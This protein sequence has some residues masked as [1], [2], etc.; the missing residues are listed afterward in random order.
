MKV[1]LTGLTLVSGLPI[2]LFAGL[3]LFQLQSAH[4]DNENALLVAQARELRS[5]LDRELANAI[6]IIQALAQ[7]HALA[8]AD[9]ASFYQEAAQAAQRAGGHILL[10][11]PA[12]FNQI[13]NTLVPYGTE[14]PQTSAVDVARQVVRD[15]IPVVSDLF[16]GIVSQRWVFNV[17]VPVIRSGELKHV[18]VLSFGA[19]HI[20]SLLQNQPSG[21]SRT[22]VVVD[23]SGRVIA[24]SADHPQWVGEPATVTDCDEGAVILRHDQSGADLVSA[25]SLL[26]KARWT[27]LVYSPVRALREPYRRTWNWLVIIGGAFLVLAL[28]LAAFTTRLVSRPIGALAAAAARVGA[29]DVVTEQST[30]LQEVNDVTR[31]LATA[32]RL[33]AEGRANEARLSAVTLASGEAI[34]SV[35]REGIIETWN[36]A[37]EQL[38]G[39]TAGETIGQHVDLLV[40][41]DRIAERQ[42]VYLR[43]RMGETV[44]FE[45]LRRRKDGHLFAAAINVGPLRARDGAFAGF[46][47]VVR[48]VS[49][50]KAREEQIAFLMRELSHRTKNLLAVVQSIARQTARNAP[51]IEAFEDR[52]GAR[53]RA[54]AATHD[55][56][57]RRDWQG[58]LLHQIVSSQLAAILTA[59]EERYTAEGPELLLL[60]AAAE[61]I[62]LA[63]HEL[64]INAAKYGSLSSET[65]RVRIGW[66]MTGGGADSQFSMS[67]SEECGPP[68]EPPASFGFGHAVI[69]EMLEYRT[70]GSVTLTFSAEGFRWRLDAPLARIAAADQRHSAT[71][72]AT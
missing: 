14:L 17:E 29:G 41:E 21:R 67:W 38:F 40:P 58:A 13:V 69:K 61:A 36:P 39:Y 31:E 52:F 63:V 9:L 55:A 23:S 7:S 4:R 50:R 60:P 46:A 15:R 12:N 43:V 8:T 65:G 27:V 19:D 20:L 64:A 44:A 72:S 22:A 68:V 34:Y 59:A 48:D 26:L 54:M 30:A 49:E 47:S 32:S 5:S 1:Y 18:L 51:T 24:N 2:L 6:Q 71:W 57:V 42:K 10:L 37:A 16:M 3:L 25:C 56:L 53:L 45:T 66:Q 70:G 11:D 35:S 62:G 28:L 33:I